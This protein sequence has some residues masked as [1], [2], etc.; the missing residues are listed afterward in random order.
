M[1]ESTAAIT[2]TFDRAESERVGATGRLISN[3]QAKIVDPV[4]GTALP[5]FSQGELWLRG[6]TIMKGIL[7][8]SFLFLF[9]Y[10]FYQVG[11]GISVRNIVWLGRWV[12]WG[13]HKLIYDYKIN[14]PKTMNQ[15]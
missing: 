2:R 13:D 11:V 8:P 3:C 10:F 6:P 12:G 1:T 9:I 15:N 14:T 7:I 4:T 5:P